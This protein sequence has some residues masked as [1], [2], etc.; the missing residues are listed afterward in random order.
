MEKALQA[1]LFVSGIVI[2]L[3]WESSETVA[4]LLD[5]RI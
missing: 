3:K 5:G 2:W 1:I 4:P